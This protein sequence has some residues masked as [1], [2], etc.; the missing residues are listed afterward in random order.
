MLLYGY[1]ITPCVD[2]ALFIYFC[3]HVTLHNLS[4]KVDKL[5]HFESN[6]CSYFIDFSPRKWVKK[7]KKTST[8]SFCFM[9]RIYCVLCCD[10]HL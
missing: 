6:I 1:Y 4:I 10:F 2:A 8:N 5:V 7:Q 9:K 3:L